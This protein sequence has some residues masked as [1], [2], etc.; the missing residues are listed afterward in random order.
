MSNVYVGF[1]TETTGVDFNESQVIQVGAVFC[2]E[3]L[4]TIED[5]KWD[6]NYEPDNFE[7]TQ[8]AQD[9]HGITK[10]EAMVHGIDRSDFKIEFE[11]IL[12]Q[13]YGKNYNPANV[14]LVAAQCYFDYLMCK[15]SFWGFGRKAKLPVS[16]RLIDINCIGDFSVG[17]TN[18][19]GNIAFFDVENDDTKRHDALYDAHK[20]IEVYR[21]QKAWLEDLKQIND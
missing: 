9:V 20:H 17:I 10:E 5:F 11:E 15:G 6:I 14:R 2:N 1:D 13:M 7:W 21:K 4:Q 18:L 16:H 12:K 3:N 19:S 8:G